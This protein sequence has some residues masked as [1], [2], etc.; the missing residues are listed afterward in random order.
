VGATNREDVEDGLETTEDT[1]DCL[2][3]STARQGPATKRRGNKLDRNQRIIIVV[4]DMELDAINNRFPEQA[5]QK[6]EYVRQGRGKRDP[7]GRRDRR[8]KV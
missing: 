6:E 5:W 8:D 4:L 1:A 2:L 3:S 7:T